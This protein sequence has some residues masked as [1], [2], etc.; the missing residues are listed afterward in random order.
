MALSR[1]EL[2]ALAELKLSDSKL[3]LDSASYS[4]A[5][6]LAGIQLS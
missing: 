3:L 1:L 5:Y 4:N 2:R 6:Y